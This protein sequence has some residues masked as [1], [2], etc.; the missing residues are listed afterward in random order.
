MRNGERRRERGKIIAT[1]DYTDEQG[2]FLFQVCRFEPKDF[3]QR[4]PDPSAI[5][6]WSW[7]VKGVRRV[8]YRL[9]DLIRAV[10][11]NRPVFIVE[12]EKDADALVKLGFVATCNAGGAGKWLDSFTPYFKGA[13][14]VILPDKDEPGRK[15]ADGV[16]RMLHGTAAQ[17]R[18]LELPDL[19]A[20]EVKD[21]S[22][23]IAGGGQ[24]AELDE[25]VEAAPEW[26][27]N[28]AAEPKTANPFFALL[29]DGAAIQGKQLPPIVQIVDGLF[30][31]GTK[32]VIGSGSKSYKTWLTICMALALAHGKEFLG[33]STIRTRALYVNL[34]LR[35]EAFER[36]VQIV[37]EAMGIRV[38]K[39]GFSTCRC[40]CIA[41]LS[42]SVL[43]SRLVEIAKSKEVGA[44]VLDPQY[45]L[46]TEGEENSSR[47]MT[48]LAN[49]STG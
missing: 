29:Q 21:V 36:R 25:M 22:D 35:P 41:G 20:H 24:A 45:K 10:G 16:A 3:R 40:G 12:G 2:T 31:P 14:V 46:N 48:R 49:G 5:D 42:L 8:P 43:I 44:V 13:D 19:G 26:D 6:G 39:A 30:C 18:L 11:D 23:W 33:R 15:H 37:A 4:K 9:P 17:I 34:E 1:Y 27:V 32:L 7:S 28:K 38:N 47:D